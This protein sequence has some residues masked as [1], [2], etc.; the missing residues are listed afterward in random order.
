MSKNKISVKR[1]IQNPF[2]R[3]KFAFFKISDASLFALSKKL[4]ALFKTED[5]LLFKITLIPILSVKSFSV[6]IIFESLAL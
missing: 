6:A 3:K 1:L 2:R 4:S 5:F